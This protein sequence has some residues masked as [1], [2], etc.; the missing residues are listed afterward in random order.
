MHGWIRGRFR[1]LYTQYNLKLY[2][3]CK[4]TWI[5]RTVR[6]IEDVAL[7]GLRLVDDQGFTA[8]VQW[9]DKISVVTGRGCG[10]GAERESRL[11]LAHLP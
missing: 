7:Q 4:Q 9:E 5:D 1:L 2:Y 6:E 8:G 11:N 10:G 3:L